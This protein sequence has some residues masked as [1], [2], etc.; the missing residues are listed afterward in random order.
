MDKGLLIVISGPS[1]AG[2]GTICK[3]LIKA[4][5]IEMS[6]SETTR[7]PRKGEIHGKNYFFVTREDFLNKVKEDGFLEY[8]EV[9]GNYYGTPRRFIKD[10]LESGRNVIL[11]IDFQGALQVKER[12]DEAVFIFILP[13]SMKELKQRIVNRGSETEESL[14]KR[15]GNALDEISYIDKY[16]YCVVN[17]EVDMAVKK[18][19][20]IIEAEHYRVTK[21]IYNKIEKYKE[22][23]KCSTPQ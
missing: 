3:E 17:D 2:K 23:I 9:Y 16:D 7:E 18:V 22:E 13:P 4:S 1:G 21:E 6:I 11:E 15:F 14:N 12:C 20:T 10:K 19:I 5:D 8:A